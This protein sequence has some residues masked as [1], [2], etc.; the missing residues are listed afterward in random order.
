VRAPEGP[1]VEFKIR[2]DFIGEVGGHAESGPLLDEVES[3]LAVVPRE[4]AADA[5]VHTGEAGEATDGARGQEASGPTEA[6]ARSTAEAGDDAGPTVADGG[7]VVP[8]VADGQRTIDG[9]VLQFRR[10]RYGGCGTH[11][12]SGDPTKFTHGA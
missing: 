12:Q 4:G 1:V 9:N 11:R 3:R 8:V 2:A 7:V 6:G 5:V 10:R